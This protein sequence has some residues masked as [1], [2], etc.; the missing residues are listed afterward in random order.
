MMMEEAVMESDMLVE[1]VVAVGLHYTQRFHSS[2]LAQWVSFS[3][4]SCL[5][6]PMRSPS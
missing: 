5:L 1:V 4:P 6:L 3:S 2:S